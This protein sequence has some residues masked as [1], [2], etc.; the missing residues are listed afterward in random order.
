MAAIERYPVVLKFDGLAA[1][2]GVVIAAGRGA[3]RAGRSRRS[4]S[5]SASAP[6][7][8][9]SRR[10][11]RARSSR[12]WRCATARR[13]CRWRPRRTTSA[14]STAT[15]ARTPA[16]WAPTRRCPA[17]TAR[18]WRRYV[19]TIHQPVV[20]ELRHRGTPFHGCLYAGLMLTADGP[21]VLEFN[22]RFGDPETQ[23]VLPRLRSDLLDLLQRSTVPG[24]LA[25]D[26]PEWDERWAVSVVLASGGYPESPSTGRRHQRARRGAR[27]RR[28]HPRGHRLGA[29]R[30]DRH[31][32]RAGAQRH[33]AGRR[34]R[35]R[36]RRRLCCRRPDH[37]RGP[38]AAT[39]HRAAGRGAH[40]SEAAPQTGAITQTE[41]ETAVRRARRRHPAGRDHHG[42][43]VRHARDGEGGR[44]PHREGHPLRGPRDVRPPRP[45]HGGRLLPQRAHARACA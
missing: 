33:R 16:A 40:M 45:R 19:R 7:A 18:A 13:P 6:G 9:W 24:G 3:R 27:R 12:C 4:S 38:A 17:S 22:V 15:A 37:L 35:C 30:G 25:G 5:R 23:A 34:P 21:R 11:S 41:P 42:L 39:R 8:W 32:R 20:D 31:R 10:R 28:G 29:R 36:P 2:K 1:G 26:D 14:S 43:E 44:D